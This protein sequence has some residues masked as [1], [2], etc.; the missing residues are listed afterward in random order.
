MQFLR[1]DIVIQDYSL[2]AVQVSLVKRIVEQL[3]HGI[4]A[5]AAV[6]IL[7]VT[8][9]NVGNRFAA[10]VVYICK[11]DIAYIQIVIDCTDS[12]TNILVLVDGVLYPLPF[13]LVGYKEFT[14]PL[15]VR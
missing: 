13:Y 7:M 5:V 14:P 6:P 11:V 12:Q 10:D 9:K 8:N 4:S 2:N 15:K 3:A 1:T